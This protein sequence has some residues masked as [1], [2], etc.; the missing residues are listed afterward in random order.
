AD[1][2][3]LYL[4]SD[5]PPER[6]LEWTETGIE[7]IW[8]YVNRLWRLVDEPAVPLPLPSAGAAMPADLP[9]EAL[10][11]RRATHKTIMAVTEDLDQFRFNRA[12]ARIREL[13]NAIETF[14][15]EA[16]GAGHALREGLEVLVQLLGPMMP[17]LAAE[18]WQRL[19]HGDVLAEVPWPKA[20]AGLA[21][22][23]LV[24]I[25]VQVNGKLRGTVDMLRDAERDEVESAA[26]AL[27]QVLRW[28]DGQP[29]RKVIVVP[30]RIVSI[31]A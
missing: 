20:D 5:S 17:H 31:V 12:V 2:A 19:G 25:A 28:L 16:P 30:N 29:P 11:L 3:R 23:E 26:L 18:M 9:A 15:G 10:A 13:S 14:A 7:G 4:M 21:R 24:T 6:D 22:D 1:T 8:R 27:P